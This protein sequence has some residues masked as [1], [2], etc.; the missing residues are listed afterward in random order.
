MFWC[1]NCGNEFLKW[2]GQCSFCSEWNTLKEIKEEK[3]ISAGNSK[4]AGIPQELKKIE[5]W[6][7]NDTK[8]IQTHSNELNTLLSWG[9]VEWSIILLS[10]EPGIWKSTLTLQL[11]SWIGENKV[12]YISAEETLWQ[13]MGR[14]SR[15]WVHWNSVS[16]LAES[17]LENIL[18]SIKNQDFSLII[19]D[20]ISVI[21]SDNANG[22]SGSLNQIRYIGEKFQEY[23]KTTNTAIWII[24]H[25]TKDGSIAGPKTLEHLVDTVLFFEGERYEDIRIL[26]S[27]KNRFGS[28]GEIAVF[29]MKSN[30]LEDIQDIGMELISGTSEPIL[31][32]A[33]SMTL[34]W[35][36]AMLIECEAL[37]NYTKFGYP[38]RSARGINISKL[39]M[40]VAILGKYT[41]V[42]LDSQDVYTN[43]TRGI[44]VEE[45]WVDLALIAAIISSK[46]GKKIPRDIIFIGEV[47]LTGKIKSVQNLEKRLKEAEKIGLKKAIIPDGENSYKGKLEIV[48]VKSISELEKFI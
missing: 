36:R 34:E 9:I 30:G 29:K 1:T 37:T 8:M 19:V 3:K 2:Q 48:K 24:G 18:E 46:S 5:T 17:N 35:S 21:S 26:R 22:S 10:G 20:S 38:K 47:S 7:S 12:C 41:W 33:L 39:D 28:T 27:L 16:I 15:L 45:P 44:K 25:I 32:A 6:V 42:K 23:A 11:C 43:I 14:A 13:I 31:W 40:I 4:I